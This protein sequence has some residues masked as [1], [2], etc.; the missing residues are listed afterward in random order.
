MGTERRT[1]TSDSLS[2]PAEGIPMSPQPTEDPDLIDE[3][4]Q[5]LQHLLE[6]IPTLSMPAAVS[7]RIIAALDAE[8][9]TRAALLANDADPTLAPI[10]LDKRMLPEPQDVPSATDFDDL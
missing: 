8:A 2:L 5:R 7:A 10:P 4:Q 1:E 9:A 3:V 6:R